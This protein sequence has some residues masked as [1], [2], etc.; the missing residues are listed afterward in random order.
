[1]DPPWDPPGGFIWGLNT[2]QKRFRSGFEELLDANCLKSSF[3]KDVSNEIITFGG[4]LDPEYVPKI[5]HIVD[6]ETQVF[7][8]LSSW[9]KHELQTKE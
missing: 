8:I 3:L 6:F 2:T 9:E 1:M 5:S 4:S 7:K